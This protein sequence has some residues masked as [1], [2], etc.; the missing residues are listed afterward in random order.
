MMGSGAYLKSAIETASP[1]R[2]V[3]ALY[4]GAVTA[5]T[6][7]REAL[8]GARDLEGAHRE[9]V[10]AQSIVLELR[11]ALDL[12]RG[13]VIAAN[14]ASLYAFCFERLIRA[15]VEKDGAVLE[16]VLQVLRELRDAWEQ[17]VVSGAFGRAAAG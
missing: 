6:R 8:E 12:E 2:L 10:R 5:T 13:G 4:D 9:L 14:L 11:M 7:A 3:L 1:E 17:A 15:N 16:P